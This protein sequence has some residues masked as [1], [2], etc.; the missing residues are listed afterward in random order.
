MKTLSQGCPIDV[1]FG[2]VAPL[3]SDSEVHVWLFTDKN[4]QVKFDP[5][6]VTYDSE[7]DKY[8]VSATSQQTKTFCGKLYISVLVVVGGDEA[9][10]PN[11]TAETGLTITHSPIS[12]LIQ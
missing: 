4:N 11:E 7:T 1:V 3:P 8:S 5:P 6:D 10:Q 2:T 12:A 9:R